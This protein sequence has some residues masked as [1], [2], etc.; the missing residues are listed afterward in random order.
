MLIRAEHVKAMTLLQ[1]L[2]IG[3][4]YTDLVRHLALFSVHVAMNIN[5]FTRGSL[6]YLHLKKNRSSGTLDILLYRT[7]FSF[8]LPFL[9]QCVCVLFFL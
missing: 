9:F 6:H 8:S 2:N 5:V 3:V 4:V 7:M 1:Q